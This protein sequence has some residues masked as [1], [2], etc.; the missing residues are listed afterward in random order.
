MIMNQQEIKER[1][2]E[3]FNRF[4]SIRTLAKDFYLH[5]YNNYLSTELIAEHYEITNELAQELIDMG[6]KI[7]KEERSQENDFLD[8]IMKFYND[9]DGLNPI[10]NLTRKEVRKAVKYYQ[11]KITKDNLDYYSWG[12]GDSIDRERV[13]DI[14]LKLRSQK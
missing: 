13:R 10:K 5:W 11:N 1:Q 14:I 3:A 2:Q 6:Y 8:Y 4:K 12:D 9:I 7:N